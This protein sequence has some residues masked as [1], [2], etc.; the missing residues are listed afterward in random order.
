MNIITSQLA[1]N[2]TEKNKSL[3]DTISIRK[4]NRLNEMNLQ[5]Q[6][7][8]DNQIVNQKDNIK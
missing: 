2:K 7:K 3:L 1:R 4:I 8:Y 6:Q 5:A